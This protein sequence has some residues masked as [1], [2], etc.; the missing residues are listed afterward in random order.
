MYKRNL[1]KNCLAHLPEKETTIIT[2][3]RQVGKTT[4][5]R[6][7]RSHL[8][9]EGL[10]AFFINLED[11]EYLTLLDTH[12]RNLFQLFQFPE[13]KRSF[14]LIDEI[15]YL[16]NPTNF[17]KYLYDEYA[18][19]IKLIVTGSSAFYLD[20][21]FRDSLAGRKRIF[22]LYTL[23]LDEF[24]L[25][26]G[27][28]DLAEQIRILPAQELTIQKLPV[29][30]QRE[31]AL[32]MDQYMRFGGFP[33]VVLA[34]TND[35]KEDVLRELLSSYVKKDILESGVRNDQNVMRLLM[36]LSSQVG[37]LL[38]LNSLA[39][40][41]GISRTAIDNYLYVLRKSFHVATISPSF[42]NVRKEIR[43]MPKLYFL[44]L[45]LRNNL[46]RNFQP[47]SQ[48]QDAG[49]LYENFIFRQF[50]DRLPIDEIQFWRTQQ[51]HEVDFILEEKI[52]CEVKY[53]PENLRPAK[54]KA[55]FAT[56]GHVPLQVIYHAG[57]PSKVEGMTF[58]RF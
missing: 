37:S 49:S 14:V 35:E 38:N 31:L 8:D 43:R 16:Q 9:E 10:P 19:R 42:R 46:M 22:L 2:G 47:L 6:Q 4:L 1:Y 13:E 56:H 27:Q 18:H 24:L 50:L 55:F 28:P 33:R 21:K 25:F 11:P 40:T 39:S 54:Y 30:Q 44:D 34:E 29:S 12:P 5:L 15:Q 58:L 23:S 57:H 36:A 45:G 41:L 3:A 7:I 52:A 53:S 32:Y 17:L 51:Q 20:E 48:R 26:H